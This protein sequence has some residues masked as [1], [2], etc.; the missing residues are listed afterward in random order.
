MI[1][2]TEEGNLTRSFCCSMNRI[3]PCPSSSESGSDSDGVLSSLL[4]TG[5]CVCCP[6]TSNARDGARASE[7]VN[8]SCRVGY[9]VD[10]SSQ[11][12][13]QLP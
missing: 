4:Q 3:M 1:E 13:V 10:S 12:L 2:E 7:T 5:Q 6:T 8:V 9:C 11:I